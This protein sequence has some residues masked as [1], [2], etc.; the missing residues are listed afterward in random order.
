MQGVMRVR[1]DGLSKSPRYNGCLGTIQREVEGG[2][3]RVVL[4]QDGKVLNLKPEN[5]VEVRQEQ[6]ACVASSS[7]AGNHTATQQ[8]TCGEGGSGDK[9]LMLVY[10]VCA[11]QGFQF[12]RRSTLENACATGSTTGR[13]LDQQASAVRARW[14]WQVNAGTYMMCM[15]MYI[16][17]YIMYKLIYYRQERYGMMHGKFGDNAPVCSYEYHVYS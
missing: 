8:R 2:R 14:H 11:P 17:V 3:L 7:H 4:D 13:G 15:Y 12:Q 1:V 6:E 5:L 10:N 16:H 9:Q